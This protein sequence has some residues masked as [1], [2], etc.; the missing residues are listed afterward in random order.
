MLRKRGK[1]GDP[2]SETRIRRWMPNVRKPGGPTS[3]F[4]VVLAYASVSPLIIARPGDGPC[5]ANWRR[6]SA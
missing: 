2:Q 5:S 3:V 1:P 4:V 6:L